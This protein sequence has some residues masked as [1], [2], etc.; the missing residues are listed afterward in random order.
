VWIDRAGL[1]ERRAPVVGAP[2][3]EAFFLL[4]EGAIFVPSYV[5]GSVR[6]MHG[7]DI[8]EHSAR[9]ALASDREIPAAIV[10][11]ADVAGAVRESLGLGT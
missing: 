5:G 4:E 11:I 6:G 10:E 8:R 2:Y 3:G 9:A 7:Y 1:Q